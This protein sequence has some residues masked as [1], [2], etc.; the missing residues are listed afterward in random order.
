MSLSLFI[1]NYPDL[2]DENT[3][4]I[5]REETLIELFKMMVFEGL[6]IKKT[7]GVDIGREL[8]EKFVE[9]QYIGDYRERTK[10]RNYSG[11]ALETYLVTE[12][13]KFTGMTRVGANTFKTRGKR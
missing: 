4:A 5:L 2:T 12:I 9:D 13:D 11:Q 10:L 7:F 3:Q 1:E 8:H 6:S